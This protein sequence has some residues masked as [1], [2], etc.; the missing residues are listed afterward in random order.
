MKTSDGTILRPPGPPFTPYPVPTSLLP[1]LLRLPI[2][3]SYSSTLFYTFQFPS[4]SST[5]TQFFILLLFLIFVLFFL[6]HLLFFIIPF[7]IFPILF[8][9][10]DSYLQTFLDYL[11]CASLSSYLLLMLIPCPIPP[12]CVY[13][14]HLFLF[15]TSGVS[16]S[17]CL[18]VCVSSSFYLATD[19]STD[20][21]FD[22]SACLSVCVIVPIEV[23]LVK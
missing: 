1:S 5:F 13:I 23:H 7:F 8:I 17:A 15:Y 12:L 10:L 22:L 6:F 20:L 16:S 4:S 9:V 11:T 14:F 18:S 3:C 21:S 19:L 2:F